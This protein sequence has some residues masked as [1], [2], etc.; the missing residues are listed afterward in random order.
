MRPKDKL[1]SVV[2]NKDTLIVSLHEKRIYMQ[3]TDQFK[4]EL[5]SIL[6]Q[7]KGDIIINFAGVNMI[8]SLAIGV[9]ISTASQLKAINQ[10]LV[11]VGL[12]EAMEEIFS[13]MRLDLIL[14][15]RKDIAE[16]LASL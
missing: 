7:H 14:E 9:L 3:F 5:N 8:N 13:R 4:Q 2:Q 1:I 6:S 10:K 12:N 15:I 11:I 16:G